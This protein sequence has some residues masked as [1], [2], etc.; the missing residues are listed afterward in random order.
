MWLDIFFVV[1]RSYVDSARSP[2][3]FYILFAFS[4]LSLIFIAFI[5]G[6][7]G[8]L[9]DNLKF[10][11]ERNVSVTFDIW[12]CCD[13]LKGQK[14][15]VNLHLQNTTWYCFQLEFVLLWQSYFPFYVHWNCAEKQEKRMPIGK[16]I[17][18]LS[19]YP[20]I[21]FFILIDGTFFLQLCVFI[22]SSHYSQ[23]YLERKYFSFYI[24]WQS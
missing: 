14:N 2:F 13:F 24:V 21:N 18:N 6:S 4:L 16:F 22:E 11:F 9:S 23:Y 19:I 1:S 3:Q 10:G 5:S 20:S 15:F 17:G 7:T 8:T 12:T